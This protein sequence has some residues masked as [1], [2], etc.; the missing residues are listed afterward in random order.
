MIPLSGRCSFTHTASVRYAYSPLRLITSTIN[1]LWVCDSVIP[2]A[3]KNVQHILKSVY[4]I[5]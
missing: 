3:L 5:F 1:V 2:H 4:N